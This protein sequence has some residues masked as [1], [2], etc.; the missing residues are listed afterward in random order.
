MFMFYFKKNKN[1]KDALYGMANKQNKIS[2]TNC[3]QCDNVL[4]TYL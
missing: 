2:F 4:I 1:F 3:W